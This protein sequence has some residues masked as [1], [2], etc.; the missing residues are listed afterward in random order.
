M[1][2]WIKAW[3]IVSVPLLGGKK[4]MFILECEQW[5]NII[6]RLISPI[7]N[8]NIDEIINSWI[9]FATWIFRNNLTS[10]VWKKV[11]KLPLDNSLLNYK[12][13]TFIYDLVDDNFRMGV[14]FDQ[15]SLM[16]IELLNRFMI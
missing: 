7:Q 1:S 16:I 8:P 2:Q 15:K 3:D 11:A 5:K 12:E 4:F 13:E 14:W 9:L 6:F 10:W